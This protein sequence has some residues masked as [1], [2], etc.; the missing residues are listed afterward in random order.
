MPHVNILWPFVPQ[1][2][3][4]STAT[5][6]Q[7]ALTLKPFQLTF[8]AGF[9]LFKQ[10]G[11]NT[12]VFLK[13]NTASTASLG[14]LQTQLTTLLP[15]CRKRRAFQPHLTVGKFKLDEAGT[16]QQIDTFGTP[17]TLSFRVD[18][19]YLIA[20]ERD[21]PFRIVKSIPLL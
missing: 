9:D 10:K 20:R 13:P 16:R 3:F 5:R 17:S 15:Q 1:D 4:V 8:D 21:T 7:H 11:N 19:V 6:L 18:R 12:V 14:A 2:E